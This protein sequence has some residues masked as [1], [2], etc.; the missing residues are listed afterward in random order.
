M[1]TLVKKCSSKNGL[2]KEV[3]YKSLYNIKRK[4]GRG[5]FGVVCEVE[6]TNTHDILALKCCS[7][8]LS[9]RFRALA[10]ARELVYGRIL[11]NP[12]LLK[13]YDIIP[14]EDMSDIRKVSYVTTLMDSDIR[15][16]LKCQPVLHKFQIQYI[17]YQILSGLCY[18]HKV[19]LIHRD[20]KP[21][22][23]LINRDFSIKICDFGLSRS[24]LDN[25]SL[26]AL[27][28]TRWYRAPEM[29]LGNKKYNEKIDLFAVGCIL[30]ELLQCPNGENKA[31]FECKS[32][33]HQMDMIISLLG[34]PDDLNW[35][36][37]E[38]SHKMML[39]YVGMKGKFDNIFNDSKYDKDAVDLLKHLLEVDPNKRYSAWEALNHPFIKSHNQLY[40]I[41]EEEDDINY[42][43]ISKI[44]F[45][46]NE[47]AEI[48]EL[49]DIIVN[50]IKRYNPAI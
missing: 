41:E 13:V 7:K 40:D 9:N 6:N 23:I 4:I 34:V 1:T 32:H 46:I 31:L 17:I 36:E 42:N 12:Y 26:T 39:R 38:E 14:P 15:K 47:D 30:S 21:D 43:E 8:V 27:V 29:I 28:T 5:S 20:L 19:G 45:G 25:K 50:E 24:N 49:K 11:D 2:L 35:I 37:N 3:N 48:D 33:S 16:L 22:N 10:L 44:D 18:L